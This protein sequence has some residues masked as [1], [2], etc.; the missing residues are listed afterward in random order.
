[1]QKSEHFTDEIEALNRP[2]GR[3][4]IANTDTL[5]NKIQI[6][7]LNKNNPDLHID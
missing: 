4:G 7:E 3:R 1:M 5:S 2:D 6:L